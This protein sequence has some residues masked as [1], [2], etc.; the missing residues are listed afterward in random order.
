[1]VAPPTGT[2]TFLFTDIEGSTRLWERN[3][4][5]MQSALSRHDDILKEAIEERGGHVFKTV[6]DAFC[7][8]FAAA[9]DALEA[10]LLAQRALLEEECPEEI[11]T[12]KLRMALHTGAAEERGG[13]YFG[14]PVNRVARLLSAGHGG[15][16]LLSLAAQ[17]LVRDVLPEGASLK[18]LGVRHLKDLLRPERV[19]QLV[20]PDLPSSFPPL[21]TLDARLNNLPAQPTPLVGRQKELAEIA[22]LVR[23]PDMRLL[24]LTGPGGTGKTRLALQAGAEL[25]DEFEDGIFFVA[26]APITDAELVASAIAGPLRVVESAQQ[27]L[28]ESLKAYLREKELLI[29]LDNFEQILKGAPMVGELLSVCPRLKV[30]ATSRT[31]LRLYGEHEYP[32]PPLELPDPTLPP[33][34]ERLSQYEAVRL[35]LERARAVSPDFAVTNENAPA[36]AEICAR[37]DGLPLAIELAAARTRLLPP[38]A[39][40]KRLG[41]RLKLLTGGARD[42][43]ERQRTLSATVEWSH[44]LLDEDEQRLFARLSVFAGGRT[45]DTVEAVCNADG[46]LGVDVLDGVESLVEKSLLRQE[47]GPEGE[48][49]FVMLE[50]IHEYARERLEESGEAEAIKRAHAEYF[51]ALAEEAEPELEGPDQLGWMDR[52]E[53]EHDNMRAALSWSLGGADVELGLRLAGALWWFWHVR[54]HLSEGRRQLEKGL[55]EKPC[56]PSRPRAKAMCGLGRLVIAQGDLELGAELLEESVALYRGSGDDVGTARALALRG[57]AANLQGDNERAR[58]LGEEALALSRRLGDDWNV[59]VTLNILAFIAFEQDD[60]EK[61]AALWE[62]RLALSREMGDIGGISTALNNAGSVALLEGDFDRASEIFEETLEIDRKLQD[63]EGQAYSLANLA[64]A[65]LYQGNHGRARALFRETLELSREMGHKM[66]IA[67]SL[68]GMAGV[69]AAREDAERTARLWGAAQTL[70]EEI[71]I[72]VLDAELP[73]HEHYRAFARSRLDDAAFEAAFEE[74]RNMAPEQAIAYAVEDDG[75]GPRPEGAPA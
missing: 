39:M 20:A 50:T 42:L 65:T 27:P 25:L 17:E 44:A 8:V 52:L 59:C 70:R 75:E 46:D 29:I 22:G 34:V 67:E 5:A 31:P 38:Q 68:E 73:L 11:G 9:E 57:Y 33:P 23:R 71:G 43:P 48:P 35:F 15:Q 12:L 32:V 55:A 19:F 54:G 47:Q 16:I 4:E 60:Q 13:D 26:L 6:G 18:D 14:P 37:L 51:L 41:N 30:L 40:L 10:A 56:G 58:T 1:M 74:G 53:A 62:E 21:K 61:A 36:V 45:L 64:W 3:P 72:P 66:N 7:A 28:E 2:V 49:R 63:K 69:A 24:T